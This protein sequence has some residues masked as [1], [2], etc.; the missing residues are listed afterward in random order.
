ML[1]VTSFSLSGTPLLSRTVVERA[2]ELRSDEDALRAGWTDAKLLKVDR[3][4]QVPVADGALVFHPAA[5]LG[6]APVSGAVFLGVRDNRH[7][8]AVRVLVQ[9]GEVADLRRIGDRLGDADAD[10]M[11]SAVALL[12]WHDQAGF[13]AVDGSASEP[14]M[15]GWSRISSATGHEEFPR[16]DPAVICLVHDGGEQVL[17]ARQPVWPERRFSVLAGFVEAGESL[18]SCVVREIREEVGV[19]V[20]DIRY[21]GSQPWPFPRSLMLGFAAVADP[22][23]PLEFRDGEI[24]EARWF[25]RDE[26]RAALEVGD[27][28]SADEVPLLLPGSISIARGMLEGWAQG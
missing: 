26:V 24:G 14:T 17:L 16:T 22:A 7:V 21:L 20:R 25:T 1:E 18:E 27:W 10:L 9:T 5:D 8:W 4:G 3:R 6:P 2:E 19:D 12:N 13:S 11:V 28:A 23:Q 15:S